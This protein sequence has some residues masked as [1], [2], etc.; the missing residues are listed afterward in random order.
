MD[1]LR[2]VFRDRLG[3]SVDEREETVE[4]PAKFERFTQDWASGEVPWIT[5]IRIARDDHRQP[6]ASYRVRV[7]RQTIRGSA[8]VHR[9]NGDDP[10]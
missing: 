1:D 3:Q 5:S 8:F 4:R 6:P 7:H 10:S 2:A 9:R